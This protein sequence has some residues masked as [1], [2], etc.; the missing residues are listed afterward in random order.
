ML[1]CTVRRARTAEEKRNVSVQ[2]ISNF[3]TPLGAPIGAKKVMTDLSF[4]SYV[5]C[6]RLSTR[7]EKG[8]AVT[9]NKELPTAGKSFKMT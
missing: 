5:D 7:T 9:E 2:A 8:G 3:R 6:S 4:E 1:N